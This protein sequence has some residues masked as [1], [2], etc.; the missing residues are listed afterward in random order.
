VTRRLKVI[1]LAKNIATC[2]VYA[3]GGLGYFFG[4]KETQIRTDRLMN[5]RHDVRGYKLVKDVA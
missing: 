4:K 1:K 3:K 5:L 2:K